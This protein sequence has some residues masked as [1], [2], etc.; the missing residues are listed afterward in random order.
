MF[1]IGKMPFI[2]GSNNGAFGMGMSRGA[3]FPSSM[4]GPFGR[5][6][7]PLPGA[8][9][10]P[11]GVMDRPY[12]GHAFGRVYELTPGGVTTEG[13]WGFIDKAKRFGRR[14]S[15][16]RRSKAA[17]KSRRCK[18]IKKNGVRCKHRTC[19]VYCK[20]HSARRSRR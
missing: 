11:T 9:Q 5:P 6:G 7:Y 2:P 18:G 4:N 12:E 8:L 10:M 20:H 1:A 17:T 13:S 16:K 15:L 14:R 19:G 3:V